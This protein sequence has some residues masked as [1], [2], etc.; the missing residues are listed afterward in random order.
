MARP[1]KT[2]LLDT[3]QQ[4]DLTAGAIER[5][6]C[7]DGKQQ[8]FLRDSKSPGLRV[9]V[10]A[11]G[12]KSFV[13]EAKLNR[14]TIRRTIGDV[15]AWSIEQARNEANRLR[16]VLDAG[17]DPRELDRKQQADKAAKQAAEALRTLT[18]AEV[19]AAYIEARRP[20]WGE[21]HYQDHI[22][23]A[24]KGGEKA[25]R[26][27]NGRGVTIDMPL[28]PLM[29]LRLSAL[30]APTIQAWAAEQAKTRPTSARLAWRLLKVF[31]NWC[32]EQPEYASLMPAKNAAA[33]RKARESLGKAKPKQDAL[34]RE[35]LPAWFAAVR[36][37]GNPVIS[38]YLQTLLLTGA[39]PGEVLAMRWEDVNMQWR[40]ITI[41]DKVEGD[42]V[43]PM[44]DYL[45]QLLNSLTRRNEWVFASTRTVSMDP[46]NIK[47]RERRANENGERVNVA[48][49]QQASASG[50]IAEPRSQHADACT[51]AGI[52]P[53]T[54]HGLRRSF[55]S[56]SEWLE[57]PA[58]VTAQIMGHKP[59]ATA[60][61]HYTV[62]PLDLLRL[63]H[64]KL[65]AWILEQGGVQYDPQTEP[66]KLRVV[67]G[68]N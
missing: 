37:V 17:T 20:H 66:G 7:P 55:K 27:T 40:G 33:T 53:V 43:I 22:K 65:V 46:A 47:R 30:D 3:G 8:V 41:R 13:F 29:A 11:A 25:Q 32:A 10:T 6:T 35:Q 63:H 50:H 18:V 38:A 34:L 39:R 52:E 54:L 49:V 45:H 51:V 44:P 68:G 14:Q 26:G 59:S 24:R 31:L 28:H 62:R 12:A 5:L 60:E 9:R 15:R 64:E 4:H 61:K 36:K 56:L 19:W 58:G 48:A 1:R 16:V 2:D 57:L 21:L 67:V 42:R 23:L